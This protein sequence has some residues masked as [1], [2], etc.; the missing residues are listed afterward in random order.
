MTGLFVP[1]ANSIGQP[2][3]YICEPHFS[4]GTGRFTAVQLGGVEP[5]LTLLGAQLATHPEIDPIQAAR[6]GEAL[7][8]VRS[9]LTLVRGGG[10]GDPLGQALWTNFDEAAR[11]IAATLDVPSFRVLQP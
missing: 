9:G 2:G 7:A 6:F 8:S 4:S 11:L 5:E 10:C 1:A 3:G